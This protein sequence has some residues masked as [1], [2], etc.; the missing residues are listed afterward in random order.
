MQ[1]MARAFLKRKG[2]GEARLEA[3]LLVA[4]ALGL[5]RLGML[6]ALERPVSG[7]EVD[8]ARDFLVRRAKREPVAY[9][10]GEREFYGRSFAVGRGCLIP[11]PESEGLIDLAK[12]LAKADRLPKEPRVLDLGTG[13]GCLAVSLALELPGARVS[14]ID[15]SELALDWAKRN[16]ERHAESVTWHLG[17]GFE[18]A[19]QL[20]ADSGPFDLLVCNP[21]YVRLDERPGLEPE[22]LDHEPDRALFA[23]EGDE[24][25]YLK[26]LLEL[27][28]KLLASGAHLLVEL[29][30][31]QGPRVPDLV[32]ADGRQCQLHRDLDRIER[33]VHV[34]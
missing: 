33:I 16:G 26:R 25:H 17:D 34:W 22:V 32:Q 30:H 29:G 28:P 15:I 5:P 27:W 1:A 8:L 10:T 3:D 23:P 19:Q 12:D 9:I 13:S 4:H 7:P 24:D 2:L 21:P 31:Q 18:V 6:L 11:R 20:A 14:A